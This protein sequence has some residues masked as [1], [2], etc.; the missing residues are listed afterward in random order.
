[1][2]REEVV[3]FAA[4]V[5]SSALATL[6]PRVR[7]PAAPP[8]PGFCRLKVE[9]VGDGKQ[10]QLSVTADGHSGSTPTSFDFP[11]GSEV[12]VKAPLD[13]VVGGWIYRFKSYEVEEL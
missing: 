2:Q 3:V 5:A 12:T 4:G 13:V 6:L 1:M 9:A 7:P 11:C 10:L 8:G